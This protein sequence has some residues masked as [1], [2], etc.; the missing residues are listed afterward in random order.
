[1]LGR[2]KTIWWFLK[3]LIEL[4]YEQAISILGIFTKELKAGTQTD[5]CM[6][7]FITVFFTIA[8]R[9]KQGKCPLKDE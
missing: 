2:W 4:P 3:K 8:K 6:H 9:L 5:T 1:M 7:V